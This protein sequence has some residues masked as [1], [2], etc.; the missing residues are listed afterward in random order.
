LDQPTLSPFS[1]AR[2][3]IALMLVLMLIASPV[4]TG[5]SSMQRNATC[6]LIGAGGGAAVGIGLAAND[7]AATGGEKAGEVAAGVVGGAL[8]GYGVCAI[9]DAVQK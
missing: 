2:P 3:R 7:S 5:C 6:A 8:I 4:L 9:M 1:C